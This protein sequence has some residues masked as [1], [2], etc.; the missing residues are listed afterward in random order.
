MKRVFRLE[1]IL[2]DGKPSLTVNGK[3]IECEA[4]MD[5]ESVYFRW[6][7]HRRER[8]RLHFAHTPDSRKAWD[9]HRAD[10]HSDAMA[11]LNRLQR[12]QSSTRNSDGK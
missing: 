10:C 11:M 5:S 6:R 7:D 1:L 4:R 9:K 12:E 3:P 8:C 2:D